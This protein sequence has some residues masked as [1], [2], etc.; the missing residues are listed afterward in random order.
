[1][2]PVVCIFGLQE[3][4]AGDFSRFLKAWPFHELR[5][6]V[7]S[8]SYL[9]QFIFRV[10]GFESEPRELYEIPEV[11]S[12]FRS[13]NEAWPFWFFVCDLRAPDLQI[14]TLCCLPK[15]S[16][17]RRQSGALCHVEFDPGDLRAF[18]LNGFRGMNFL[19]ERAGMSKTENFE[20]SV[21][22]IE[23]FQTDWRMEPPNA[24]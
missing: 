16:V 24:T 19:F 5:Q 11:R 13:L 20:R 6:G 7:S 15:L 4:Q 14:M 18:V 2:T 17:L 22:I 23:Y 21:R 3:I 8:R 9:N 10:L 1:M 12:F